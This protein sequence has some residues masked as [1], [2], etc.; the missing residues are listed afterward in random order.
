M[1]DG[2]QSE[3]SSMADKHFLPL[4]PWSTHISR[5]DSVSV[6]LVIV[7]ATTPNSSSASELSSLSPL[8]MLARLAERLVNWLAMLVT[9]SLRIIE[10][11]DVRMRCSFRARTVSPGNGRVSRDHT[12]ERSASSRALSPRDGASTGTRPLVASRDCERLIV[13]FVNDCGSFWRLVFR[14]MT[15]HKGD[16]GL[17]VIAL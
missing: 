17:T 12:S 1:V 6:V 11:A 8:V 5:V 16:L 7:G 4:T 15:L 2:V 10:C 13:V 9:L 3:S 14:R